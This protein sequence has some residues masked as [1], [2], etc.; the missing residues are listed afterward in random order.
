MRVGI[1][2]DVHPF[3]PGRPLLLGGVRFDTDYG[4]SGHS[5]G[6]CLTHAVIDA[7]L[8]AAGLGDIGVH[9]PPTDERYRDADSIGLLSE[10][11]S[12]LHAARFVVV[13]VDATIVA[14]RPRIAA[15]AEAIRHRLASALGVEMSQVSIKATTTDGLGSLGRGEG[16]AALAVA[17]ID[18]HAR[19]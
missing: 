13:N 2:Y 9:F 15:Q 8:G 5:D 16:L 17:L 18:E 11:M 19:S 14:E 4:L 1:G 6:D 10:V 7:V 3:A 12:K